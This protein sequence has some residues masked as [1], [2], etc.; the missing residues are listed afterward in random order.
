MPMTTHYHP[1]Q[2]QQLHH[3]AEVEYFY[4]YVAESELSNIGNWILLEP[5]KTLSLKNLREYYS[6]CFGIKHKLLN[7][8]NEMEVRY[9]RYHNGY[10]RFPPGLDLNNT[11]FVAYYYSDLDDIRAFME[12]AEA[13]DKDQAR[14][15]MPV[16]TLATSQPPPQPEGYNDT[17][18]MGRTSVFEMD[19]ILRSGAQSTPVKGS[20]SRQMPTTENVS[21]T[22]DVI[23]NEPP[24]EVISVQDS[25]DTLRLSLP[26]PPPGPPK[27]V[28][29][30][31]HSLKV[32]GSLYDVQLQFWLF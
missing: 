6:T 3:R 25:Q 4:V 20:I 2:Q 1:Q 19:S 21:S 13:N 11:R 28:T 26:P 8:K 16:T 9:I 30:D 7:A 12:M 5:D 27:P 29:K 10:F 23:L 14:V 15:G 22:S 17:T 31:N 24:V 18:L 32:S